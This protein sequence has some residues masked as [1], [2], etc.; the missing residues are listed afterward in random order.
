MSPRRVEVLQRICYNL[1]TMTIKYVLSVLKSRFLG[2]QTS[3]IGQV[4]HNA[5]LDK[6]AMSRELATRYHM[7]EV[8]ARYQLDCVDAFI[9]DQVAQ[10]NRLNFAN[11]SVSL[12][13]KGRI[14]FANE[15]ERNF[16]GVVRV[17]ITPTA[18]LQR[19]A[20]ALEPVCVSDRMRPHIKLIGH[21]SIDLR[22]GGSYDQMRLDGEETL[23]NAFYCQVDRTAPDEGYFLVGPDDDEIRLKAKIVEN[24]V[25]TATLVFPVSDLPPGPYRIMVCCRGQKDLPLVKAY[26]RVEVLPTAR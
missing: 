25:G 7:S 8:Q 4:R 13:M 16:Q 18:A 12:K 23:L 3:Y 20:A 17:V 26:R 24:S 19:T 1:R 14:E 6:D 21:R 10:G 11:F 5:V 2:S 15:R 9:A 22:H